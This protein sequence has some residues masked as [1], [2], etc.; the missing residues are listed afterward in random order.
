MSLGWALTNLLKVSIGGYRPDFLYRCWPDGNVAW[1][2]PGVPACTPINPR[3]V[4]EGRK[5]FPSG[6]SSMSFSGL[7]YAAAYATAKLE[8]FSPYDYGVSGVHP[9]DRASMLRMAFAWWPLALATYV[10]LSRWR[11][12]W[13]H[14]EDVICGSL[15]GA[16]SAY[17]GWVTKQP[18][19]ARELA[20]PGFCSK[21]GEI[22][23]R[24]GRRAAKGA[25]SA[26]LD[27]M[28]SPRGRRSE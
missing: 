11:D 6:H 8:I 17:L 9:R 18:L 24:L 25:D 20:G 1:A 22:T 4:I 10:A 19:E 27:R 2:S 23:R 5:S 15:L 12:Y 14:S 26:R 13:H 3:H 28:E 21:K 16:S 7:A